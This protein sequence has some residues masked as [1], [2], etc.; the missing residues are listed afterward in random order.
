MSHKHFC[1]Q[2]PGGTLKLGRVVATPGA[3]SA[4]DSPANNQAI[5]CPGMKLVTGETCA[6]KTIEKTNSP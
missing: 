3:L 1:D 6:M 2:V 4:L 5:F